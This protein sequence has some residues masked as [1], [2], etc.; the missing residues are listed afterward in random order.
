[1][2]WHSASWDSNPVV[3]FV[4]VV[5]ESTLVTYKMAGIMTAPEATVLTADSTWPLSPT[6]E[7]QKFP[8]SSSQPP[9]LSQISLLSSTASQLM[10]VSSLQ[11][12][13]S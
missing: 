5:M 12:M 9:Q 6:L 3:S 2:S 13:H 8:Q 1:M 10:K 4:A 7:G 11:S